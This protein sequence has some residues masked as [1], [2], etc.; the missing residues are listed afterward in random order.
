MITVESLIEKWEKMEGA[1]EIMK[2]RSGA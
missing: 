2:L 1:T